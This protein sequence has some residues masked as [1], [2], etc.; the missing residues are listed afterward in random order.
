ML[1]VVF[2]IFPILLNAQILVTDLVDA[3]NSDGI[4]IKYLENESVPYTGKVY[5]YYRNGNKELKGNYVRGLKEGKWVWWHT[6]GNRHK[7]G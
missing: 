6:S 1:F 2:G 5:N 4:L 3:V 7:V